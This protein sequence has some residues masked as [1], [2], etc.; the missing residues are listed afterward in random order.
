MG[1]NCSYPHLGERYRPALELNLL[2]PSQFSDL[3]QMPTL[4]G[5]PQVLGPPLFVYCPILSGG[6]EVHPQGI[7][8]SELPGS[9][10]SEPAFFAKLRTV[11]TLSNVM[12]LCA[13]GEG[14]GSTLGD[15][16]GHRSKALGERPLDRAPTSGGPGLDALC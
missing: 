9:R 8:S 3:F 15:G 6:R 10:G 14:A 4:P 13:Q 11:P 1:K 5:S 12:V 2:R 7:K 16:Q